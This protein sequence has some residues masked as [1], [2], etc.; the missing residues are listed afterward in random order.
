MAESKAKQTDSRVESFLAAVSDQSR[1]MDCR[2][3]LEAMRQATKSEPKM[4]GTSIVGFGDLHYRYESGRE[5]DTFILGFASRM[6]DLTIY[7]G[8]ALA[9]LE[10]RL[11]GLGKCKTGKGCLYIPSL[12]DVDLAALRSL[13]SE[14]AVYNARTGAPRTPE[15][16]PSP[17]ADR[18]G[19]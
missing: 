2:A 17:A 15:S 3:L 1:R 5:G 11:P 6:T 8:S 10:D 18:P 9:T 16:G 4:W 7:L 12:Q 14:A 19:D 13:L